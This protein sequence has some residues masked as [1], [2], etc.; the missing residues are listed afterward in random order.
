MS[1]LDVP[2]IS[3]AQLEA[4]VTGI[5]DEVVEA[6][7]MA[8]A[9]AID[10]LGAVIESHAIVLQ[11]PLDAAKATED[12]LEFKVN[13]SELADPTKGA[14]LSAWTISKLTKV[15][16]NA[17]D[18]LNHFEVPLWAFADLA[19]G[20]VANGDP[21]TWDW[22]PAI[23]AADTVLNALST[24]GG[25]ISARA[26][27]YGIGSQATITGLGKVLKGHG[28]R[29]TEFR[30][31]PGYLGDIIVF[32]GSSYCKALDF[33]VVGKN[34]PTQRGVYMPYRTDTGITQENKLDSLQIEAVYEG[35]ALENPVHCTVIDIR[36]DRLCTG[37]GLRSQFI[38]QVGAGQGG[39]NLRLIGG[40]FQADAVT[41]TSCYI[42]SNT[43]FTSVGSQF[44]HGR[45]GLV[46]RACP[47]A[48]VLSPLFEDCGMHF[49]FQGCTNLKMF[50]PNIDSGST[51]NLQIATQP[52][53]DIDGGTGIT[54]SGILS[55]SDNKSYISGLIRYSSASYAV[56]PTDVFIDGYSSEGNKGFINAANVTRLRTTKDGA[57]AMGG[58]VLSGL[59]VQLPILTAAPSSPAL[60]EEF[61][62]DGVSWQPVTGGRARVIYTGAGVYTKIVNW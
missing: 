42:N 19:V 43:S 53:G 24:N 10:S 15:I 41:G 26:G 40:W 16:L 55:F 12:A 60:G 58:A 33:K 23:I 4:R 32:R 31:L 52:I 1:I 51:P 34:G 36:T 56:Y 21:A 37:F 5:T 50:G 47:G 54:I 20:Y 38:G 48:T 3:K 44:E 25:C 57:M 28:I 13:R 17:G 14:G 8:Q 11:A 45:F 29:A 18:A 35:I 27:V 6:R 2:G 61:N 22:G 62:A 30:A 9:F 39:T 49:A 46:L 7:D 59:R